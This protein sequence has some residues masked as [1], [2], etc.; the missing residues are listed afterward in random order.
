MDNEI[1]RRIDLAS[2]VVT[3]LAGKRRETGNSDGVGTFAFLNEPRGVSLNALGTVAYVVR[4]TRRLP[5]GGPV[6]HGAAS[7]LLIYRLTA[8]EASSGR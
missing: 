6:V 1:I 7:S 8:T 4:G 5:S 3:S 2:G